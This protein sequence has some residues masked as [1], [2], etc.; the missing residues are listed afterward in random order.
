MNDFRK[1]INKDFK[2]ILKSK[3]RHKSNEETDFRNQNEYKTMKK[4]KK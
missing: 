3:K 4:I 2:S 1:S